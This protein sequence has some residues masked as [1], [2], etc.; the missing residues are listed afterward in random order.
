MKLQSDGPMVES[1]GSSGKNSIRISRSR[2]PP[3][4]V[5]MVVLVS[6]T[7]RVLTPR[8]KPPYNLHVRREVRG[9]SVALELKV[10]TN[11]SSLRLPL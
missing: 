7:G 5:F 11:H 8:V 10:S 1:S 2:N 4:T 3:L 9:P 6:S